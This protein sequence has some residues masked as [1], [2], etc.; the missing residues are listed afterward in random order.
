M[1]SASGTRYMRTKPGPG[2]T[3]IALWPSRV[4]GSVVWP[5]VPPMTPVA[6]QRSGV[7]RSGFGCAWTH[8]IEGVP[9]VRTT[10]VLLGHA[11]EAIAGGELRLV[12]RRKTRRP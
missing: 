4:A 10:L 5:A 8:D 9:G 12:L 3:R 1:R 11:Y 2:R 7:R 6:S